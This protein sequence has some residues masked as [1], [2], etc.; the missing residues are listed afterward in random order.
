MDPK[1][2]FALYQR[3]VGGLRHKGEA[4]AVPTPDIRADGGP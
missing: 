4:T 3:E 1:A 2:N